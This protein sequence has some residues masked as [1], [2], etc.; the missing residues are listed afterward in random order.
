[1]RYSNYI[2]ITASI[3][4][5]ICCF[6]PWVYIEPINATIT[7]MRAEQTSYGRPGILHIVFSVLSIVFF[8]VPAVWA[9]RTNLFM[10]AF[11]LAWAIRNFLLITRCELGEC[12]E[13]KFGIYALV[14]ASIVMLIMAMLPKVKIE[15]KNGF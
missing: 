15:G 10:V 11:N 6:L 7:G 9:K 12:P 1:M 8:L 3:F 2:G 4:L 5:I 13:K 14:V